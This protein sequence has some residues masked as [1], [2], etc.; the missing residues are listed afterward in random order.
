MFFLE[1]TQNF[2]GRSQLRNQ[3]KGAKRLQPPL[4]KSFRKFNPKIQAFKVLDLILSITG[5]EGAAQFNSFNDFWIFAIYCSYSYDCKNERKVIEMSLKSLFLPQNHKNRPAAGGS[6]HQ[7]S[8]CDAF[9][10]Y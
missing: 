1:H 5:A 8:L 10:L 3:G 9:E 6:A 2:L 4:A 7:A